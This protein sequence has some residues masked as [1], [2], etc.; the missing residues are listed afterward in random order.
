MSEFERRD[1]A[2]LQFE[3]E[4]VSAQLLTVQEQIKALARTLG[5]AKGDKQRQAEARNIQ[6]ALEAARAEREA[7]QDRQLT[8]KRELSGPAEHRIIAAQA[9]E[10]RQRRERVESDQRT[11]NLAVRLLGILGVA[12]ITVAVL[13]G[14][15][16]WL[17]TALFR[18]S[19]QVAGTVEGQ[20][21]AA[22]PEL[23]ELPG[24]EGR[25]LKLYL[26]FNAAMLEAPSDD[27]TTVTFTVE[28]GETAAT[29]A[30]GLEE[31]GLIRSAAVFRQLLRYRQA[32]ATLGAG[33][34]ELN[35]AMSMDEVIVAL[36]TS[37]KLEI[38]VTIP[39]GWRAEQIAETLA[40][41]ELFPAEDYMALV[42]DAARFRA[43]FDFLADLPEGATLE[44][45][46][47]PDTYRV[48]KEDTTA[49]SFIRL[50]LT[51]FGQ[52]LTP[53]LR[54]AAKASDTTIFEA[55]TL[56]SIVE[57]EA[58][59]A[60]ERPVIAGVFINRWEDG[61]VLN[62]DPTVQYAL[63]MQPDGSWWKTPLSLDDLKLDSPYNTYIYRNLPP[64]PICN[65]GASSIEGTITAPDTNFYY[66]VAKTD[67]SGQHVFAE[68][69]EE[70][71]ANV[72]REQGQ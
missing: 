69:L 42:Q 34:F 71:S 58:V 7:L 28:P 11:A 18:P 24:T 55:V 26:D 20:G 66:F 12:A 19:A 29:I 9:R 1:E 35:R 39:E 37:P 59:V 41:Q 54:A 25:L 36:Q 43:D 44:G 23:P 30:A 31:A 52:R 21:I 22:R 45:Y 68:T 72:A 6:R 3:L 67:G 33:T 13:G 65:P 16:Y 51:T 15:L 14:G 32:D 4:Q 10:T 8:L 50:Q 53:E 49:E 17:S 62:A 5:E 40:E 64:G 27:T 57:R 60:E 61:T 63:G 70:H 47:F 56:A 38:T 48:F 46:L 2:T